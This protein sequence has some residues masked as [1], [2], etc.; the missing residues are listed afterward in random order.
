MGLLLAILTHQRRSD[1]L[2]Q[3]ASSRSMAANSLESG[4]A[5]IRRVT[6]DT[7]GL[8]FVHHRLVPAAG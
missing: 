2:R 7:S 3:A 4:M 6:G 1:P 5:V 8:P